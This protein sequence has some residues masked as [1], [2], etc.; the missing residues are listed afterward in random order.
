MI[1]GNKHCWRCV[2]ARKDYKARTGREL[3]P[4]VYNYPHLLIVV[5]KP[6]V[7]SGKIK[8]TGGDGGQVGYTPTNA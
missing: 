2:R 5:T 4:G 8:A 3:P 6:I 7:I 1:C